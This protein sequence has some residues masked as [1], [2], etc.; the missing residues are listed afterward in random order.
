V[1]VLVGACG[2][3]Q[4]SVTQPNDLTH[5][6]DTG[7]RRKGLGLRR[8]IGWHTGSGTVGVT[9]WDFGFDCSLGSAWPGEGWMAK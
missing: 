1:L 9:L 7:V 3:W 2:G 5:P 8:S 6:Y 4:D